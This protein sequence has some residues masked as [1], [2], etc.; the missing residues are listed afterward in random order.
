MLAPSMGLGL[1]PALRASK[2]VPDNFV[3]PGGGSHPA[4]WHHKKT[5]TFAG[6]GFCM[7]PE[8]SSQDSA[9]AREGKGS[10]KTM[11]QDTPKSTP[12]VQR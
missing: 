8:A 12:K 1:R 9:D 5:P 7:V 11:K 2:I 10:K 3:E 6:G 4:T